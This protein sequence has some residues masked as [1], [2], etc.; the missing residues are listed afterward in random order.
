MQPGDDDQGAG[1]GL[2]ICKRLVEAQGGEIHVS[3]N[4]GE[5]STFSFTIPMVEAASRNQDDTT[6][7]Q[8][9]S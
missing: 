9:R 7:A 1:V 3:S 2:S 8:V 4:P 6:A 5:G